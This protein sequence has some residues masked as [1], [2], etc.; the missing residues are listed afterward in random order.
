MSM[1]ISMWCMVPNH[2]VIYH[3]MNGG[4]EFAPVAELQSLS[5]SGSA[6]PYRMHSA[7]LNYRH[8]FTNMFMH[9]VNMMQT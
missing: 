5:V 3:Y 6:H 1:I 8:M 7:S 4:N 9:E 2:H